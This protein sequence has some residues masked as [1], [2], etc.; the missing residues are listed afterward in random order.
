MSRHFFV[1]HWLWLAAFALSLLI[2]CGFLYWKNAN[3]SLAI[4]SVGGIVSLFFSVQKQRTEELRLFK[5][6]FVEFNSR[7]DQLNNPLNRICADQSADS[8][9]N[10]DDLKILNDYFNLCGEEFLFYKQGFI[11]EEA[12]QAW[13]NGMRFFYAC[14]RIQMVWKAELDADSYYG[15]SAK[16]L[17]K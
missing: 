14:P 12:W 7:Y 3:S 17:E 13:L 4:A 15:L 9:T 5:E 16:H 2:A 11:Y 1:R 6:L 10:A 8:I